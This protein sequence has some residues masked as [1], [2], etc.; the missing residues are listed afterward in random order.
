MSKEYKKGTVPTEEN[1]R[2]GM[3]IAKKRL[4]EEPN[5]RQQLLNMGL[6]YNALGNPEEG[7]KYLTKLLEL[8][9]PTANVY[10]ALST[11]YMKLGKL[12]KAKEMILAFLNL[13]PDNPD[14]L[15][16]LGAMHTSQGD[17]ENGLKYLDRAHRLNPYDPN[18]TFNLGTCYFGKKEYE[19][20][21]TYYMRTIQLGPNTSLAK[22]AREQ[23]A[24]I[25]GFEKPVQGKGLFFR[26]N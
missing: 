21:R 10:G 2:W 16:N 5:D 26:D 9:D 18:T 25:P 14:A 19:K 3:E 11:T 13:E 17:L 7:V 23:L 4:Q 22:T 1:I 24:R 8:G 15:R 20:A 6:F 12:G